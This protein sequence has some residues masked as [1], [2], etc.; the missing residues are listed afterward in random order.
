M[1]NLNNKSKGGQYEKKKAN[2]NYFNINDY[3]N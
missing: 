1:K 2:F 3:N